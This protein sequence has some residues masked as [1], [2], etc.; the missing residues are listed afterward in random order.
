MA[1]WTKSVNG[2]QVLH[3]DLNQDDADF[4]Q[5]WDRIPM[6]F[7]MYIGEGILK[8]RAMVT[9]ALAGLATWSECNDDPDPSQADLDMTKE[10]DNGLNKYFHIGD[11]PLEQAAA[12]RGIQRVFASI[13][14]GLNDN[15]CRVQLWSFVNKSIHGAVKNVGDTQPGTKASPIRAAFGFTDEFGHTPWLGL[16][17]PILISTDWLKRPPDSEKYTK[18]EEFA[19]LLVHEASHRYAS[20]KD[21]LYKADSMSVELKEM[22]LKFKEIKDQKLKPGESAKAYF[23][24]RE[25]NL[26]HLTE[27]SAKAAVGQR[28]LASHAL[29]KTRKLGIEKDL[30]GMAPRT[31]KP[32]IAAA[33]WLENADSYA[34]FARRV[35]RRMGSPTK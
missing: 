10:V 14:D 9:C 23:E 15:D 18:A 3:E 31:G 32:A 20:T 28:M 33:Q 34:W 19:R 1:D 16:G 35:W 13:Q 24:E 21:I 2:M 22:D 7:R 17:G 29:P 8:S 26:Q 27:Q 4:A 12:V 11:Q 25:F 5:G 6:R 30:V